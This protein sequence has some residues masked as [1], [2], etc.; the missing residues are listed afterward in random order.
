MSLKQVRG[1]V[2]YPSVKSIIEGATAVDTKEQFGKVT[3]T[4]TTEDEEGKDIK[5]T[6]SYYYLIRDEDKIDETPD[7]YRVVKSTKHDCLFIV[8]KESGGFQGKF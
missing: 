2:I 8:P 1:L 6:A 4:V 5:S 7:A 3:A